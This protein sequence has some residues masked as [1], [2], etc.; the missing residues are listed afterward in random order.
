M[1]N[2]LTAQPFAVQF[3][4]A[5][6]VGYFI[7]SSNMAYYLGKLKGVNLREGG[8]GNLGASNAMILLGKRAA[9]LTAAHDI[10]KTVIAIWLVK[11]LFPENALVYFAAGT[12]S[13]LGHIFPFYLKFRG[14]KGFASFLGMILALNWRFFFAMIVAVVIIT[15]LSDYIV[16]GTFTVISA[17]PLY[18][19]FSG[20]F[21]AAC[22]VLVGT[23]CI[24]WKHRENIVRL[25]CGKE[26]G[27]RRTL[28]GKDRIQ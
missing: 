18:L 16:L 11:Q 20:M 27:L 5:C 10:L 6:F 28:K 21:S 19:L 13:V 3:L 15:L 26:I 7:G 23:T 12:A 8:S 22:I 1:I 14:G 9:L 25:K 4:L 2:V 17:Y 24:F